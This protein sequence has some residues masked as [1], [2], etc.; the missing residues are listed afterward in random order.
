MIS[1]KQ[2]RNQLREQKKTAPKKNN[3]TRKPRPSNQKRFD[4]RK[5]PTKDNKIKR[6]PKKDDLQKANQ[7]TNKRNEKPVKKVQVKETK[8]K[9]EKNITDQKPRKLSKPKSL[10]SSPE[11]LKNEDIK[12]SSV[13]RASN[14]PR[15]KRD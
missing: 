14:D 11:P 12:K 13:G 2:K 5:S 3:R 7:P 10:K 1:L 6:G 15:N 8:A 9:E 4:K